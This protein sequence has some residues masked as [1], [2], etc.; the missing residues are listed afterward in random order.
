MALV[1]SRG[2]KFTIN[3]LV[4]RYKETASY[5]LNPERALNHLQEFQDRSYQGSIKMD[6]LDAALRE[7][8]YELLAPEM[9][10]NPNELLVQMVKSKDTRVTEGFPVV[11]A[12]A[13]REQENRVQ[14]RRVEDSLKSRNHKLLFYA[15]LNVSKELFQRYALDELV[16]KLKSQFRR[17]KNR[18]FLVK[19][20]SDNLPSTQDQNRLQNTFRRYFVMAQTQQTQDAKA[21]VQEEFQEEYLLSLLLSPKQKELVKKKLRGE[22]MT[23]T[24]REYF[25]RV[26]KK[27]LKALAD[28]D[29]HRMA[30]KALQW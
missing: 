1:A 9:R 13:L 28:P 11:L 25:S 10:T 19:G 30:Q 26:V 3:S 16:T 27:K 17:L 7:Y 29:L 22:T 24:E 2:K 18:S 8:G 5:L 21:M 20:D 15:L 14:L 4:K 12:N 23:K 6:T